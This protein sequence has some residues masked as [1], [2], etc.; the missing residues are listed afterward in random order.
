MATSEELMAELLA[1]AQHQLRW[2]RAAALPE[3]R[4][5]VEQALTTTTQ[6]KCYE[7][8]DGTRSGSEAAQASGAS[9]AA[10][11]GWAR[12]WRDLGIAY[13]FTPEAGRSRT[14][15]LISLEDLGL[16]VEIDE[17]GG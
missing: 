17:A 15:H 11:S 13:E 9:N 3:V 6:R 7:A 1:A 2:T 8:L 12:R 5:T 16:P 14:K 4:G 10:V